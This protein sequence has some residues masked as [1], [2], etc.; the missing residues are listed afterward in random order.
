MNLALQFNLH[1]Q[2]FENTTGKTLLKIFPEASD[3]GEARE[4]AAK[5]VGANPYYVTD[6]KKIEQ[7][8]PEILDHVKQGT[9]SIPQAKKVA[10]FPVEQRSAA[11]E[12]VRRDDNAEDV[13]D[14]LVAEVEKLREQV[15]ETWH[16]TCFL[17]GKETDH[18]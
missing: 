8:A 2:Q 5:M 3:T 15:R 4:K 7:D 18:A 12:R 14:A 6:A 17:G 16:A 9:L 11:I 13:I 10:A 1:H